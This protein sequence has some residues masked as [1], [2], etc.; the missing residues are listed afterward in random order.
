MEAVPRLPMLSFQLK[1]SP[2]A[3]SFGKLKQY[4]RDFYNE[5][6]ESY[7]NEIHQLEH[8]RGMAARPPIAVTGCSVLKKYYC[9]LHFV[10]SR[11]PMGTD[12][13]AA[14]SFSW[15]DTYTNM[16]FTLSNI[17]F[18]LI[19]ILYNIGAIHSQLGSKT[20]R[21]SADGMKLA[22]SHFQCAAW[23]FEHLQNS[24]PHLPGVDMSPDLMKFM[25]QLS[26]AQ[27][28]ECILEK[29]M[30]DNRKPTIVAKVAKQIVD[31][32]G[33]ALRTL[34]PNNN[35]ESPIGE[36]VGSKIYKSW[37]NYVKFKRSYH[38]SVTYLYQGL[39]AEEQQ[40]M[41]ERV[42]FY[43]AALASLN[44]ARGLHTS[45]K[46]AGGI[47]GIPTER[48]AIEEALVFTNDVIEGKRKAAKNEN[49][50]IYH[51]EVPEKDMLP[52]VNGASL[53]KGISFNVNDPEISGPD[54][55]ARLVPMQVHEASSLYSEEKAKILRSVG[56]NIE[57][58][59]QILE[60]Y[61]SSLKLQHL[62]L[63]DPDIPTSSEDVLALP[64]ELVERCAALNARPNAIKDLEDMMSKLSITY[65]DVEA[66]LKDI[67]KL[68]KEEELK[69]RQYQ[70]TMGKRPPSIVAT[71]LTREAKKY[72]EA[73]AKA[74]ESNQA[75]HRAMALH[76]S[77]LQ[78]LS[79]PLSDLSSKIPSIKQREGAS[80]STSEA[81]K[82]NVREL[83]R[84][85]GKVEEMQ[86]QR[87]D[88]HS[89]LRD[90]IAQ[91]NLTRLLVTAT[92][93]SVP[94]DSLFT[95][96]LEKH[97]SL[98][99]LINK[100]LSAQDNI[101]TALTDAY[102]R[103]AET[104]KS[105][106]EVLKRREMMI[107]SLI[108]SYDA[109]EDLMS[110]SSKGLEFYRKLEVNVTKLLQRVKS[111]CRVQEEEREQIIARNEKPH[112][113]QA[114]ENV[115]SVNVGE[116]KPSGSG[117]KLRDHL[118]NRMK[119]N[120]ISP[121]NYYQYSEGKQQIPVVSVQPNT[122]TL[123]SG[124][125]AP[126]P[127]ADA[128]KYQDQ[129]YQ[130]YYYPNQ[131][132]YQVNPQ[133]APQ[134]NP[135]VNPYPQYSV[136]F[137]SSQGLPRSITTNSDNMY[138]QAG[139]TP[140]ET[141]SDSTLYAGYTN[142][143]GDGEYQVPQVQGYPPAS[144]PQPVSNPSYPYPEYSSG[145][146]AQDYQSYYQ[147]Q[148][149]AG[150]SVDHKPLT[151]V[152]Q[153]PAHAPV[154]N[155]PEVVVTPQAQ[156]QP[157]PVT[158][159]A[160]VQPTPVIPQAQVH[161]TVPDSR[162]GYGYPQVNS[163]SNYGNQGYSG[164][165]VSGAPVSGVPGS[166]VPVSGDPGNYGNSGVGGGSGD[167]QPMQ[168]GYYKQMMPATSQV[169]Q[170]TQQD[171]NYPN[172]GQVYNQA[173]TTNVPA[174]SKPTDTI[175]QSHTKSTGAYIPNQNYQNYS[176][177]GHRS[178]V[179]LYP[180]YSQGYS[181]GGNWQGQT[182]SYQGHPGY[183]YDAT[184]G[185][186][187]YS[188]GYSQQIQAQQVQVTDGALNR[189]NNSHYT[190]A[191]N[192]AVTN[193]TSSPYTNGASYQ[194]N[195][196]D[197]D[198]YQVQGAQVDNQAGQNYGGGVAQS[199]GMGNQG[200]QGVPNQVTNQAHQVVPNQVNNQAHHAVG[201]NYGGGVSQSGGMSNQGQQGVPNQV[202]NQ[203]HQVVPNQVTNQ[204]QYAA[205]NQAQHGVVPNQAQGAAVNNQ[206]SQ[207]ST[208]NQVPSAY[209]PG[210]VR[211]DSFSNQVHHSI[212]INNQVP[213]G[214]APN[215]AP[216]NYTPSGVNEG[217][218]RPH[219]NPSQ[220]TKKSN[221]DLLADLDITINHAP[222]VPEIQTSEMPKHVK[223]EKRNELNDEAS[224]PREERP[225]QLDDKHENLQI[226]W[227]T[228][229][230]DVQPKRD[231]LGDPVVL[232][233]FIADIE[234]Y[235][236]FVDSL[237]VK[238]LSGSTNLENKWREIREFEERESK[239]QGFTAALAHVGENRSSD[240]IPYDSTRVKLGEGSSDYINASHVKDLTQWTP[241]FIIT[242]APVSS[243]TIEAFWGMIWEQGSEV[244]ACL[245]SDDQM[246]N[247]EIYWPS[248]GGG[249]SVGGFNL[250][251]KTLTNHSSYVRRVITVFN[252]KER[253]E[254]VVVH[255]QYSSWPR[256]G[257]PSS[258]GGFLSF[259]T[260]IMSEQALRHCPRPIVVHCM[261]GG[262]LS[263]LFVLAAATVCHVRAGHGIVDVP[264]VLSTLAKYRKC[265]I[266]RDSLLFGY[267]MVL[268]YAQDS[269]MKR[270]IL[271]STRSTFDGFDS[272]KGV[273]GIARQQNNETASQMQSKPKTSDT[274]DKTDRVKPV[275]PL[276]QLDPLWSIR[277]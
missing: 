105:V 49:E 125:S 134:V 93:E 187:Q 253:A 182:D 184:S 96:Q 29:S 229:Y 63:W 16:V 71:D 192:A 193:L 26:L 43:N 172:Y 103:T 147:V 188:S 15:K 203:A 196:G 241:I 149:S 111:T 64:E 204:T 236:K 257:F 2:E 136:D 274:E 12:E 137:D 190:S 68:L 107:T 199:G 267:R 30:L 208:Y 169:P 31:Y 206:Q 42:A 94:L 237:T 217:T 18:E 249:L 189:R 250:Q 77:N 175:I 221:L 54:I 151:T 4:I 268:Y 89:K 92:A 248:E 216:H 91:D 232:Q 51:E 38:M 39:A 1:V 246:D 262:P 78:V 120:P 142:F 154:P 276:S 153:S 23:A 163:P 174:Y 258:P 244:V 239:R 247:Q 272:L 7:S 128:V 263:G 118:I 183:S 186:Y 24:Y 76:L 122:H 27:A 197:K 191:N 58:K 10:Q 45:A 97:Q 148:Q 127:S 171:S 155:R 275:D 22:C 8:L 108:A 133:A 90:S 13:P 138:R 202:T 159:Q 126:N 88:L 277:K 238:T 161:P 113:Y 243:G 251:L 225:F 135:Q 114:D 75:L 179:Q 256:G 117:M 66:M 201:N 160:H 252:S 178:S 266:D 87:S 116:K 162:E 121:N 106:D 70:E 152:N 233:K 255:M 110:K 158:P 165:S 80:V 129:A 85:L 53:V 141:A 231:P 235:E 195:G 104:R 72:E 234:K 168:M 61:L 259:A 112:V 265:L 79:Q 210:Q 143:K 194:E 55:F 269:L 25:Q 240:W 123:S 98:V 167:Q 37:K 198:Y 218:K 62:T 19:S 139:T 6:P 99:D 95:E 185:L 21:T 102:A 219:V 130:G 223:E 227:D 3:T 109:Y 50:F 144:H 157:I 212:T 150:A 46:G 59:D 211:P 176:I 209:A 245:C 140:T 48:D 213:P 270:G 40:K 220:T 261:T 124:T 69:E 74:S 177:Q 44:T 73:H 67:D 20:E 115:I 28:Q 226:V 224:A 84:I 47:T 164:M 81:D 57:E 52:T 228:W 132:Y 17:R 35:D 86:R 200:Q 145:K 9:Q 65:G 41:G 181:A 14:V 271:S 180:N 32:Y 83:K 34:E 166:G 5:D 173:T 254:K 101:L 60:T 222:L 119:T 242:Q 36:A 156:V 207:Q 56:G 273:G 170:A 205:G 33:L 82:Q 230:N 100:N 264:L 260:D 11:F 131:G 214:A 215:Q 146:S